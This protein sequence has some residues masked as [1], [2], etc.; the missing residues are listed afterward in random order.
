MYFDIE[1]QNKFQILVA[2]ED[3]IDGD[4]DIFISVAGCLFAPSSCI[5][6]LGRGCSMGLSN[7]TNM[8]YTAIALNTDDAVHHSRQC[9]LHIGEVVNRDGGR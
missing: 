9:V 5:P 8:R 2:L 1:L 7:V 3:Q 6:I 4:K